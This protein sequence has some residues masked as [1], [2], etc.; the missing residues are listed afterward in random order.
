M[1]NVVVV[2]ENDEEI[3]YENVLGHQVGYGA[4]QIMLE[5]GAQD[6]FNNF[7]SVKIVLTEEEEAQFL[8]NQKAA[9]DRAMAEIAAQEEAYQKEQQAQK[10]LE[11]LDSTV[12]PIKEDAPLAN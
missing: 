6:V 11:A 7:K 8:A 9:Q 2:L 12:V 3:H 10:D 4:V 5:N 1:T